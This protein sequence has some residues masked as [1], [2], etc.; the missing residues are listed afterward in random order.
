MRVINITSHLG[1]G[2]GS[3]INAYIN[4]STLS[5]EILELEKTNNPCDAHY[6]NRV[7]TLKSPEEICCKAPKYDVCLI[8]YYCCPNIV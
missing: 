2:L 7:I 5:H 8:H 3:V 4:S 6:E 1:A